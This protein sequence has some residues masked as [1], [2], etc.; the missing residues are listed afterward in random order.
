MRKRLLSFLLIFVLMLTSAVM[1]AGCSGSGEK[2]NAKT[3][4]YEKV[5][6]ETSEEVSESSEATEEI[7]TESESVSNSGSS[8]DKSGSKSSKSSLRK[9]QNKD[10]SSSSDKKGTSNGSSGSSGDNG[11]EA[12]KYYV[13]IS[14]DN[15]FSGKKI[16]LSSGDTVYDVLKKSGVSIGA[17]SSAMGIY[18]YSINGLK[19]GDKGPRSG[20]TYKVNGDMPPK[21]ANA[22]VLNPGDSVRWEFVS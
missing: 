15:A 2:D 21:S 10:N 20:W 19:E 1:L 3:E 11:G 17:E 13:T 16:E 6:D 7:Q 22:Y 12:D 14:V 9:S 5:K 8:A 18:V 4:T